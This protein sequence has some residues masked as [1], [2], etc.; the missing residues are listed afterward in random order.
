MNYL[1]KSTVQHTYVYQMYMYVDHRMLKHVVYIVNNSHD[2]I[3]DGKSDSL[4][5]SQILLMILLIYLPFSYNFQCAVKRPTR[6]L[7]STIFHIVQHT[8]W[9]VMVCFN[10]FLIP[11]YEP[12]YRRAI[13]AFSNSN[14]IWKIVSGIHH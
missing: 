9:L 6:K 4:K 8:W 2:A 13:K 10:K 14:K 3:K 12:K 1:I 11:S 7:N 5:T